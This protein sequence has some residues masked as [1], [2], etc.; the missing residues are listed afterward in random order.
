METEKKCVCC[1]DCGLLAIRVT[2][3]RKTTQYL[4]VDQDRRMSGNVFRLVC[5]TGEEST[6]PVCMR[7]KASFDKEAGSELWKQRYD[8]DRKNP[9]PLWDKLREIM[10]SKRACEAWTLYRPGLEPTKALEFSMFEA[11]EERLETNRRSWERTME[12]DRRKFDVA[13]RDN[14]AKSGNRQFVITLCLAVIGV[15][16]ALAQLIAQFR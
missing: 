14:L 4:E 16:I 9:P 8:S 2:P 7:G 10:A 1:A 15:L 13:V 12:E 11:L 5:D 6:E 3:H